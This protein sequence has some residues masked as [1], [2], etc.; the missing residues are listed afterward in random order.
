MVLLELDPNV[1]KP[2]WI[3]LIIT[4]LLAGAIAF[5][6]LSMRKQMRKIDAPYAADLR[7]ERRAEAAAAKVTDPRP[8]H[9]DDSG[10]APD[11]EPTAAEPPNPIGR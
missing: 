8:D 1:V 2:G 4:I 9:A 5:L 3:P 7:A 6:Y 10:V 11:A